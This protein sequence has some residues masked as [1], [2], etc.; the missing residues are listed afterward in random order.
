MVSPKPTPTPA[1]APLDPAVLKGWRTVLANVL[2]PASAFALQQLNVLD[3][4]QFG[5]ST[6]V[7][8]MA[9]GAINIALRS[10]TSTP[11]GKAV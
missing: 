3:F 1:P 2:I 10:I 11:I 6:V 7:A 5:L 8:L 4:S 9:H